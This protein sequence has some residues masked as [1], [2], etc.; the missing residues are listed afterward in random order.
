M[1]DAACTPPT[2]SC[3]RL[4]TLHFSS[5][6][7]A[8]GTFAPTAT[9]SGVCHS[10]TFTLRVRLQTLHFSSMADAFGNFTALADWNK[11]VERMKIYGSIW[12]CV[13]VRQRRW[14][15][16]AK[17]LCLH[18]PT[19]PPLCVALAAKHRG[20]GFEPGCRACVPA[21]APRAPAQ[22]HLPCTTCTCPRMR[23]R[24]RATSTTTYC[25]TYRTPTSSSGSGTARGSPSAGRS[26]SPLLRVRST[27]LSR[28]PVVVWDA[29]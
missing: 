9:S 12:C 5:M 27:Y 7:D 19:H 15:R 11:F 24:T 23:R 16:R 29:G 10:P 18:P 26:K 22:H 21:H 14:R 4:Q 1:Q 6:A 28:I 8:F 17:R 3:V 13:Q 25:T 2:D 20:R